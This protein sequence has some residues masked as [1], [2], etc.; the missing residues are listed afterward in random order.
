MIKNAGKLNFNDLTKL[1]RQLNKIK[2]KTANP[3]GVPETLKGKME[4]AQK[5][6]VEIPESCAANTNYMRL[7]EEIGPDLSNKVT[8]TPVPLDRVPNFSKQEAG[9]KPQGLWYACGNEW[10]TWVCGEMPEWI[11]RY[12]Y[13][14]E[15][16]VSKI[17]KIETKEQFDAFSK[18]Y[19][20][21]S[22]PG[23]WAPEYI[24]WSKVAEG[25]AASG[26][27]AYSGIEICPQQYG[28]MWY[29]GWDVASGCIW[30]SSAIL[31]AR[32]VAKQTKAVDRSDYEPDYEEYWDRGPRDNEEFNW[33]W[34]GI[35]EKTDA[36]S[37]SSATNQN[38]DGRSGQ[39][40]EMIRDMMQQIDSGASPWGESLKGGGADRVSSNLQRGRGQALYDASSLS[41]MK[42]HQPVSRKSERE[43]EGSKSAT[44]VRN[45]SSSVSRQALYHLEPPLEGYEYVVVSAVNN[46]SAAETF[47]FGSNKEGVIVGYT[48]LKGSESNPVSHARALLNAGYR[49][50]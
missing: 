8:M 44:L 21:K 46:D 36:S 48:A 4:E 32:L 29:D 2:D 22:R 16:D 10:M 45:I 13:T 34:Y 5:V 39:T 35:E 28:G 1:S 40:D 15:I 42:P 26:L 17:L 37:P 14:L 27:K 11:G 43:Q 31:G 3:R 7:I 41:S 25:S 47:I 30:D 19:L 6:E 12:V 18:K 49:L 9:F 24:D 23:T 33:E 38:A 20:I 50:A